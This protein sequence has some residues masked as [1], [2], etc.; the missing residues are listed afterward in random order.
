MLP[1]AAR[2]G[3]YLDPSRHVVVRIS[4][5]Y[6]LPEKPEWV[7][8]A[9]DPNTS[10]VRIR[11]IVTQRSLAGRPESITWARLPSRE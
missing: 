9:E 10:L 5:P 4:S 3:V 7:R 6:W 1:H 2:F 11:E 8:V